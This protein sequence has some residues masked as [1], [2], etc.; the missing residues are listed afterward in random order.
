M[1]CFSALQNVLVPNQYKRCQVTSL[2]PP[3]SQPAS[4]PASSTAALFTKCGTVTILGAMSLRLQGVGKTAFFI[5][6]VPYGPP[7]SQRF[8]ANAAAIAMG[9]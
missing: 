9:T 4:Q 2:Q 1:D 6:Q 5:E 8:N 3:A 7:N